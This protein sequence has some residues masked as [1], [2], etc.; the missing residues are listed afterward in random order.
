MAESGDQC[1]QFFTSPGVGLS[2][3]HPDQRCSGQR[4]W[5]GCGVDVRS[6]K[7]DQP[8]DQRMRAS[9]ERARATECLAQCGHQYRYIVLIQAGGLDATGAMAAEHAQAV[10]IVDHQHGIFARA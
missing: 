1:R 2:Q 10:R 4:R 6:C 8:F 5:H 9:D 7:L 3:L